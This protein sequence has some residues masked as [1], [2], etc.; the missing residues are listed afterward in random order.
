MLQD[1]HHYI[2][3]KIH[4]GEK[5]GSIGKNK[6]ELMNSRIQL[7]FDLFLLKNIIVDEKFDIVT[8]NTFDITFISMCIE[9]DNYLEFVHIFL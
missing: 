9:L 4:Q 5:S 8:P 1:R 3:N 6:N 7:I 2:E